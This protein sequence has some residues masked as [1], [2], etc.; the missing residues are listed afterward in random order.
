MVADPRHRQVRQDFLVLAEPLEARR[1]ARGHDQVPVRQHGALRRAGRARGVA[2][3][4]DVVRR[5]PGDLVVEVG[6]MAHLELLPDLGELGQAHEARLAVG[7]HAPRIVVDHVLQVP[8]ARPHRQ[9]LVHLLLVLDDGEAGLGVLDDVLHLLLDGVLV[10]RHRD[11]PQ[12]LGRHDRPVELGPVVA[13]DG[14]AVAAREAEGG[15]AERDETRLLEVLR[16]RIR[17]PDPEIL[18]PD[19]DLAPEAA[20][21][22][23]NE[24]RERVALGVERQSV[25]APRDRVQITS[26]TSCCHKG[27]QRATVARV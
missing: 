18:F 8:A 3:D 12:R 9:E 17:L 5:A 27:G 1:V 14:D 16:P 10:D 6:G 7:A 24:L 2:D 11:A 21:V 15:Q 26:G 25:G 23:P 19:G 22:V 4:G 13:D 20:R